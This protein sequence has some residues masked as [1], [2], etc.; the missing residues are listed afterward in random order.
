MSD[1][2]EEKIGPVGILETREGLHVA[3]YLIKEIEEVGLASG[4]SVSCIRQYK[5]LTDGGQPV[6]HTDPHLAI[7]HGARNP[8]KAVVVSGNL[9]Y[10]DDPCSRVGAIVN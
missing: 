9:S 1:Y 10:P 5:L 3:V 2:R 7:I 4:R 8:I 6:V